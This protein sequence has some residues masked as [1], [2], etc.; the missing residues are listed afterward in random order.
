MRKA[1]DIEDINLEELI[2]TL[3]FLVCPPRQCQDLSFGAALDRWSSA[4]T[5]VAASS[6]RDCW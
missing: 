6:I 5:V 2:A 4:L 3:V 1:F